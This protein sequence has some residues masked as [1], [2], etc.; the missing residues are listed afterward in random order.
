[1]NTSTLAWIIIIVFIFKHAMRKMII[2]EHIGAGVE[3]QLSSHSS[4]SLMVG[5]GEPLAANAYTTLDS[6]AFGQQPHQP[7]QPHQP[8]QSRQH[9]PDSKDIEIARL[10]R[11]LYHQRQH[12]LQRQHQRQHHHQLQHQRQHQQLSIL[13]R[14]LKFIFG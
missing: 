12:Q 13:D 6:S 1:M 11:M 8:Q 10:R 3:A 2:V 5:S 4:S 14:L 9:T 7:H